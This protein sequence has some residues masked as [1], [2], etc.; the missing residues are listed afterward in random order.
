M[1]TDNLPADSDSIM[2][3]TAQIALKTMRELNIPHSEVPVG[4]NPGKGRRGRAV[5]SLLRPRIEVRGDLVGDVAL[6][7]HEFYHMRGNRLQRLGRQIKRLFDK[8]EEFHEELGAYA[9]TVSVRQHSGAI[10]VDFRDFR[11]IVLAVAEY[12]R[13]G[14]MHIQVSSRL[15]AVAAAFGYRAGVPL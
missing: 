15:V 6:M 10:A 11:D 3:E 7:A 5:Y 1:S 14:R 8:D 12:D 4:T 2:R 13:K 9:A